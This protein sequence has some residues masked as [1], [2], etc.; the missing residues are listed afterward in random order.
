MMLSGWRIDLFALEEVKF[1][2]GT[3]W[4]LLDEEYPKFSGK[5]NSSSQ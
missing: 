1:T 4:R 2:V 3:F 5:V